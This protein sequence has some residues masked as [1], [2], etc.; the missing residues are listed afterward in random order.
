[1]DVSLELRLGPGGVPPAD[2]IEHLHNVVCRHGTTLRSRA[3]TSARRKASNT[4]QG[5]PARRDPSTRRDGVRGQKPDVHA[6]AQ[7]RLRFGAHAPSASDE[8]SP[9]WG[10]DVTRVVARRVSESAAE[11]RNRERGQVS[12]SPPPIEDVTAALALLR[13]DYH[14]LLDDVARGDRVLWIGAG[15]SREQVPEVE[16]LLRG[17]LVFLRDKI[18]TGVAPDEHREALRAI[19]DE[20]LPSELD[21]FDK[22]PGA[23]AVP[24]D[25]KSLVTSYSKILATEV[26]TEDQDYLLWEGV[27]VRTAYGD[28]GISPGAQ[29]RLIAVLALEGALTEAVTTN[30]D[31]L[32]EKAVRE[33]SMD[34]APPKVS[35]LMSQESFREERARFKLYKAHGCAVL[36]REDEK[37][38]PY[39]VAQTFDIITWRDNPLFTSLVD[40]L[41][42]LAKNRESLMLG[43]SIQDANLLQRIAAATQDLVWPWNAMDPSCVFAE[44][45]INATHKEVLKL[46]YRDDYV[47]NRDE[48][49]NLSA[50]G[51]FSGALLAAATLHVVMEKFKLGL[52][53]AT[54]FA[55]SAAVVSDLSLGI[56]EIENQIATEAGSSADLVVEKLTSGISC[57]VQR[58]FEPT[59]ELLGQQYRPVHEQS[60]KAGADTQFRLLHI[61]ELAVALALLGSGTSRGYW[62]VALGTGGG[63]APRGLLLLSSMGA[64][65][66]RTLRVVITRDWSETDALKTTDLW[67]TDSEDLLV[68]QVI[69]DR[70]PRTARGP[71]GGLGTGRRSATREVRRVTWMSELA[72]HAGETDAMLYAFQAEVSL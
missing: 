7:L 67:A 31:G 22:D 65:A 54:K 3:P 38:R 68:V 12:A 26:G 59:R 39:L 9:V 28:P 50:A 32:T 52:P 21:A 15:V 36:A 13:S 10:E 71:A 66:G 62:D 53:L 48:I 47:A 57:L 55:I 33:S 17:V 58:F 69:G 34:S 24:S 35:V 1:M 61:P 49:C 46:L 27:D 4:I 72:V 8:L 23:W 40:K 56:G 60:V 37:Y 25:L 43:T 18:A 30:W 51:M 70:P 64:V 11:H 63:G 45:K 20:H 29:H 5:A 14:E 2:P 42:E 44:P 19:V 6:G 41:R 16:P